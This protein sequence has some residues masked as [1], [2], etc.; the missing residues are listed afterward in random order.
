MVYRYKPF[1]KRTVHSKRTNP[2][3]YT[4]LFNFILLYFSVFCFLFND[5]RV[6]DFCLFVCSVLYWL[7]RIDW[8]CP[9]SEF[10]YTSICSNVTKLTLF[11]ITLLSFSPFYHTF[12][13]SLYDLGYIL[14]LF[15][16][17]CVQLF[18]LMF[19]FFLCSS[20]VC[21]VYSP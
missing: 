1:I 12:T 18:A 13:V 21:C 10:L 3:T 16:S 5:V 6:L 17:V 7:L 8:F 20:H 19:L 4:F 9:G 11:F 15:L 2:H 14:C